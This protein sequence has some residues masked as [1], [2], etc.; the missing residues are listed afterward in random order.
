MNGEEYKAAARSW[1]NDKEAKAVIDLCFKLVRENNWNDESERQLQ[2]IAVI[3]PYSVQCS[4]ISKGLALLGL[5]CFTVDAFQGSERDVIIVSGVRNNE[6][7]GYRIPERR[8]TLK[9]YSY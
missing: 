9:C 4:M 8:S 2:R 7:G 3:S 6:R 1:A 5:V